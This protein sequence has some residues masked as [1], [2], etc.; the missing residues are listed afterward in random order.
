MNILSVGGFALAHS[1]LRRNVIEK[2]KAARKNCRLC[3]TLEKRGEEERTYE[4]GGGGG[5]GEH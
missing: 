1:A 4:G 5:G 2:V 3:G